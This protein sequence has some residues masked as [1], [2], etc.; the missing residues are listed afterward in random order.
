[1]PEVKCKYC[2]IFQSTK[3][4]LERHQKSSVKCLAI[5]K[6]R[7]LQVEVPSVNCEFCLKT[8]KPECLKKHHETCL[9]KNPITNVSR[10]QIINNNCNIY[11]S[12]DKKVEEKDFEEKDDLVE[13]EN[14]QQN[15][16]YCLIERE[17]LK[18][19]ESIYK[20]G[21]T[22]NPFRR[23]CHYPK[24]SE[25]I[26]FAKVKDCNKAEKEL[27]SLLDSKLKRAPEI[28][29]EYYNCKLKVL[30]DLFY[31]VAYNNI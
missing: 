15:F 14:N 8:M 23:F 9:V 28:G 24:G 11:L 27:L 6:S 16:I 21:K 5:Q 25:M 2:G 7:G 19:K 22:N 26:A 30:L 3:Y 4:T 18:T 13:E 31:K 12:I 1:M 10:D 29:R 17:F 20:V